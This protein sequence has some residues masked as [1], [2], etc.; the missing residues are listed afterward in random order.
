MSVAKYLRQAANVKPFIQNICYSNCLNSMFDCFDLNMTSYH[1]STQFADIILFDQVNDNILKTSQ[2]SNFITEETDFV[3]VVDT[4]RRS[5]GKML[6]G[7]LVENLCH[8][9]TSNQLEEYYKNN[10]L[11]PLQKTK[12]IRHYVDTNVFYDKKQ[13]RELKTLSTKTVNNNKNLQ[14]EFNKYTTYI[15]EDD[16]TNAVPLH[17]MACGCIP[18]LVNTTNDLYNPSILRSGDNCMIV[19]SVE[20]AL[21]T[22]EMLN[23]NKKVVEAMKVDIKDS[24]PVFNILEETKQAWEDLLQ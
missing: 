18:I 23:G 19:G 3:Q 10:L 22:A 2:I 13:D 5:V 7:S 8:V 9:F 15:Q 12:V 4:S 14:E 1:Y 17:A 20:E 11:Y 21:D 24:F 6:L 16:I